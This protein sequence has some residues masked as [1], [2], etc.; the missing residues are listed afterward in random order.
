MPLVP[1]DVLNILEHSHGPKPRIFGDLRLLKS[2]YRRYCGINYPRVENRV[3]R[4]SG[5]IVT[6]SRGVVQVRNVKCERHLSLG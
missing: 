2:L 1:Y 3:L 5:F 4:S 6:S